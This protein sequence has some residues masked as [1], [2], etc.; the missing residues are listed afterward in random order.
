M[1][2][3]RSLSLEHKLPLLMTAVLLAVLAASLALTYR[4][5]SRSTEDAA[6]HRLT[7]AVAQVAG[8]A[9]D[10][11]QQRA[12]LL[13]VAARDPSIAAV[14][15]ARDT[16][17]H[18]AARQI[19]RRLASPLDSGLPVE[20]WDARG[21][22]I[23]STRPESDSLREKVPPS[24]RAEL[25]R[26]P[27]SRAMRD[28]ARV[29]PLYATG[30]RGAFWVVAPIARGGTVRGYVAQL[31]R[32]GGARDASQAL[33]ELTGE[34]VTLYVRNRG[35]D[36]WMV[37]PGSPAAAPT[38]RDSADGALS[39]VRKGQPMMA[40]EAAV[41]GTPWVFVLEAP[42]ESV[43]SGPRETVTTLALLSIALVAL[44]AAVS[45][46][47]SRGITRPLA[48]LT[49]AAEAIAQGEYTRRVRETGDDEIGRL[50]E[51]FN[52][53][54]NQID[55]SRRE[56]EEG[57]KDARRAR[58]EAEAAN[59]AKSDFLAVMS[60]ELRTPL[61]AIGG[62]AQLLEMGIH[63]PVTEAQRDALTRI[64]RSQ[65]HLLSLIND[66]LNFAKIDAGQI[67]FH[68]TDVAL[69]EVRLE[70]EAIIAPQV[71]AKNQRLEM[72]QCGDELTVRADRDKVRQIL[73]NLIS[74]AVK[75]TP[76]G[77]QIG[78]DCSR[79]GDIVAI[80]V[81]DTG[82]G[83]PED[84]LRSIFEPF[85]QAGRA[86]NRTHEGVGLGLAISRDLA[87]AMGGDITVESEVGRGSVF[88]VTLPS[89]PVSST[90]VNAS[91]RMERRAAPG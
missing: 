47:I 62:Y 61:N 87:R 57:V 44:G 23:L 46:F 43:Q 82:M 60:H 22:R 78:V 2:R 42:V 66:V 38:G 20:V 90:V 68:L 6:R 35:G 85:V 59:R 26:P 8:T 21:A 28:S 18:D 55:A 56:L 84:R 88:T 81:R 64:N 80:R 67:E 10:A 27:A 83:I 3:P 34:Q 1:H 36:V 48:S 63:G 74:N 24:V 72:H 41:T 13:V 5:L 79:V 39:Y 32:T 17:R 16:S 11:M 50:A 14:L 54:A 76:E 73:L 91:P 70:L 25:L 75:F 49:V 86:L 69:D 33:R 19:L 4:T 52:Q 37:A 29:S 12:R 9:Q 65:A 58:A 51:S 30:N 89:A 45:W 40:T 7:Q 31:L 71:R 77:G 15:D 53:M